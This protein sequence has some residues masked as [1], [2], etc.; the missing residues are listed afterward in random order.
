M[1]QGNGSYD[2]LGALAH[3]RKTAAPWTFSDGRV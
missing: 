1:D 2:L 3:V